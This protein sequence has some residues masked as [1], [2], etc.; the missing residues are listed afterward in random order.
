MK[1]IFQIAA[2]LAAID[3]TAG[4]KP[5]LTILFG[6]G[7]NEMEGLLR[8]VRRGWP[9]LIVQGSGG[10]ADK[11]LSALELQA[12]GTPPSSIADPEVREI[13]ETADTDTFPI[14]GNAD[15]LHRILMARIDQSENTL[16]DGWSRYDDLDAEAIRKQK[17]WRTLQFTI[18]SLGILATLFAI[19][20]AGALPIPPNWFV[21]Y[22]TFLGR[23]LHIL[24]VLTPIAISILIAASSR[25]REGNKWIHLRSAAE[26]IKSEIFRYRMKA[27][28]YTDDECAKTS[29]ESKLAASMKDISLTLVQTEVNRTSIAS[30]SRNQPERLTFLQPEEYLKTRL[31][32]QIGYFTKKI[33]LLYK[34][35][36]KIQFGIY[37][38]G[39]TGTF[40]AAF[41]QDIW[42]ALTTALATAFAARLEMD[43]IESS[44]VRYNQALTNLRN[45]R[46]WWN[47]LSQWE[48]KRRRNIDLLV[49]QTEKTL[50]GGIAGWVHQMQTTLD[51]LTEKQESAAQAGSPASTKAAN[52]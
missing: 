36:K 39:G 26:A 35:L 27:A 37:L 22:R 44:L 51:K 28:P 49:E 41:N 32:D 45:I 25:F 23:L 31:D 4:E 47:A 38:A 9:I 6:G 5:V 18:L 10:I 7:K 3:G 48:R 8:S 1:A 24:I 14:S 30:V 21:P 17:H 43:Q 13:I 12:G 16:A 33:E 29:R 42:V 20:W 52:V 11:I 50:E 2:G 15:D 19:L 40:L 34:R 46:S